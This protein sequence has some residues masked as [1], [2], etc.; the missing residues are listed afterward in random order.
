MSAVTAIEE[1][2]RWNPD[3][4]Y[5]QVYEGLEGR[6]T[7]SRIDTILCDLFRQGILRC[8]R[9][10][11]FLKDGRRLRLYHYTHVMTY[12]GPRKEVVG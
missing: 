3:V 8:R 6:Y 4:N 11:Y 9:G 10:D 12:R 7:M 5:I 2:V 1:Y